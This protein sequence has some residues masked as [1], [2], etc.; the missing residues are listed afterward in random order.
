MRKR[1]INLRKPINTLTFFKLKK[2]RK[3]KKFEETDQQ[4]E[5]FKVYVESGLKILG[6]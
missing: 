6:N 5:I 3:R 2:K 4:I 1:T